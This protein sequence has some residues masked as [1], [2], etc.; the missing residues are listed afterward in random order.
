M[1]VEA[2]AGRVTAKIGEPQ[3]LP[4]A[5]K[6]IRLLPLGPGRVIICGALGQLD[7]AWCATVSLTIGHLPALSGDVLLYDSWIHAP[8]SVWYRFHPETFA[9][10]RLSTPRMSIQ[11][12]AGRFGLSAHYGM[13]RASNLGGLARVEIESPRP[14]GD[15]LRQEGR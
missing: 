14:A 11:E 15:D 8:G 3:G 12:T 2:P 5:D 1:W 7:R 9:A 4:P 13:V 10:E 6:A